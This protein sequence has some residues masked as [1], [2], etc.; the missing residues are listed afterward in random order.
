MQF[1]SLR[2]QQKRSEKQGQVDFTFKPM[3]NE[4]SRVIAKNY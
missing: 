3:I 4:V 1:E 2:Q